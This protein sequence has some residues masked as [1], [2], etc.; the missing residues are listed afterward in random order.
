MMLW[1]SSSFIGGSAIYKEAKYILKEWSG[2][3]YLIAE[4]TINNL[5]G[6]QPAHTTSLIQKM[7]DD[8]A[9]AWK[10]IEISK[11]ASQIDTQCTMMDII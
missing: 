3:N 11:P 8:T 6:H 9:Y 7:E 4:C 2:S 5:R 10:D 1:S